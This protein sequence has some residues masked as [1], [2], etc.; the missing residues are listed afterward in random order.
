MY[1]TDTWHE[2]HGGCEHSLKISAPQLLLFGI[3]CVLKILNKRI[4]Y[5]I[6]E[7]I[8]DKGVYRTA[9]A[10]PGLSITK[11]F[12]VLQFFFLSFFFIS[13]FFFFFFFYKKTSQ[14]LDSSGKMQLLK[15]NFNERPNLLCSAVQG[16][17]SPPFR[18]ISSLRIAG[19]ID[20][21]SGRLR[22]ERQNLLRWQSHCLGMLL[23]IRLT[24][25]KSHSPTVSQCQSLTVSHCLDE[26]YTVIKSI[27][28]HHLGLPKVYSP[29]TCHF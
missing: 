29:I 13:F 15:L 2:T 4:T 1:I 12:H 3:D 10:T 22:Q 25:S 24:M 8:N 16:G 19:K 27:G 17:E 20:E 11:Y 14:I 18:R 26:W 9:P 28:S 21:L 23:S 7:W 6:N 5:W